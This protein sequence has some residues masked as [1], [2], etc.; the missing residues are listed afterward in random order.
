MAYSYHNMLSSL[1]ASTVSFYSSD[2]RLNHDTIAN[3]KTRDGI[4]CYFA[5]KP[6]SKYLIDH[7]YQKL[8]D[9]DRIYKKYK[10][11]RNHKLLFIQYLENEKIFDKLKDRP[12]RKFNKIHRNF[13]WNYMLIQP[14]IIQ[15]I[16]HIIKK[17]F[18]WLQNPDDFIKD[19]EYKKKNIEKD[20]K[21][22][23]FIDINVN[24]SLESEDDYLDL[25]FD[26]LDFGG[27]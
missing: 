26:N 23:Q 17:Y 5:V 16:K 4:E 21:K 18:S 13:L 9:I 15:S 27:N 20:M 12:K 3:N 22:E 11:Y 14:N 1:S 8:E 2:I 7:G 25:D 24:F 10:F 19:L 6:Y